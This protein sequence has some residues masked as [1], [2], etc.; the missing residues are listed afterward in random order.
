MT[1]LVVCYKFNGEICL[2]SARLLEVPEFEASLS[3]PE[4]P[5]RGHSLGLSRRASSSVVALDGACVGPAV[6]YLISSHNGPNM[7]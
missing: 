6:G 4:A 5:E 2:D 7:S 3:S 1:V